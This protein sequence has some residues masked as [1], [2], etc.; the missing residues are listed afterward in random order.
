MAPFSLVGCTIF[1]FQCALFPFQ[2]AAMNNMDADHLDGCFWHSPH[3]KRE[4]GFEGEGESLSRRKIQC[5]SY[6]FQK[7]KCIVAFLSIFSIRFPT[8]LEI[9]HTATTKRISII[10]IRYQDLDGTKI[11]DI[12][13]IKLSMDLDQWKYFHIGIEILQIY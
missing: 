13:E 3:Q 6:H 8:N 5:V 4:R 9:K 1:F 7:K 10:I 2:L 11:S 12:H